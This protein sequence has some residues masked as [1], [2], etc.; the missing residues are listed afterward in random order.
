MTV[1]QKVIKETAEM[2]KAE[3]VFQTNYVNQ[4]AINRDRE[5]IRGQAC[6][7]MTEYFAR[8]M[9]TVFSNDNPAFD[10]QRF[11]SMCGM[12]WLS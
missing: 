2:I 11:F 12:D 7:D 10:E 9:A 1:S 4:R 6:V 5:F 8:Q 3:H